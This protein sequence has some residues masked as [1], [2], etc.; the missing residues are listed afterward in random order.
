MKW[1]FKT[2]AIIVAAGSGKRVGGSLP[3]QFHQVAG[4]PILFYT[5]TKFE[6]CSLIDEIIIVGESSWLDF[7]S[8]DVV[9]RFEFQK[10]TAVVAGGKERQDSVYCGIQSVNRSAD[11]I[12]VHDA[13]RPFVSVEKIEEAI[14]ACQR[15]GAAI[16]AVSPKDTIKQERDGFVEKTPDRNQLWCVQTPQVFSV[17]LLKTAYE[18]VMKQGLVLTDDAAVVERAG[19]KVKIVSGNEKNIKITVPLDLKIAEL[20]LEGDV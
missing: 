8:E 2:S 13:V 4:R 17:E 20:L 1:P 14:R 12:A 9:Q 10:V 11:M 5:V 15:H 18:Q 19:H 16:L 3:K 7:I 6:K